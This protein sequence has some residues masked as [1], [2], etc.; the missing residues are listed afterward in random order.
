MNQMMKIAPRATDCRLVASTLRLAQL[1]V[2]HW[3]EQ[4]G[5]PG[6]EERAEFERAQAELIMARPLIEAAPQ[7]LVELERL[8]DMLWQATTAP[9]TAAH[10]RAIFDVTLLIDALTL[11]VPMPSAKPV[12][13][14][15][16]W[17]VLLSRPDY[18]AED[19]L[20][21]FMTHVT[22]P[23]AAKAIR[24]A[25]AEAIVSDYASDKELR[26]RELREFLSDHDRKDYVPLLC[27]AGRH[28]DVKP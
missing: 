5:A 26:F 24:T 19:A 4:N 8:R 16:V 21:T 12:E 14:A 18:I 9:R 6:S 17:T 23:S 20:D 3:A 2:D 27:I 22:A 11:R 28:T 15:P 7:M 10:Q 13:T 1:F 25:Q